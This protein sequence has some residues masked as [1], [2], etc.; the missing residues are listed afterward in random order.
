MIVK[1]YWGRSLS[2]MECHISFD[3]NLVTPLSV[4]F[5]WVRE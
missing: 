3:S 4:N 2:D 5:V 1:L